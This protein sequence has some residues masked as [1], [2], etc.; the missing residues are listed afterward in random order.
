MR[1]LLLCALLAVLCIFPSAT[2]AQYGPGP[3]PGCIAGVACK[4]GSVAIGGATIGS[5]ALGVTGTTTISGAVSLGSTLSA[6]SGNI[7]GVSFVAN[8]SGNGVFTLRSGGTTISSPA[9]NILKFGSADAASPVAQTLSFQGV[10]AGTSNIAGVN[11]T[12]AGSQ[13]TGTGAGGSLILQTAP[14]GTTGSAQ[15]AEVTAFSINSAGLLA[16]PTITSD[17]TRTDASVCED[18]TT[19]AFYSGSGTLGI[20]LG[21]SSARYKHDIAPLTVGLLQIMRLRPI[22]YYLNADH[23]DPMHLLYGFTAE[24]MQ[25]VTP[26]LV[27]LDKSGRP[28][29]ADYV[30]LIPV[31]VQA[32]QQ[33]Q[34]EIDAL[35]VR[36]DNDD[37]ILA[38]S[39]TMDVSS[40]NFNGS[41]K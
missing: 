6:L 8:G 10:V 33:Q 7:N 20:C 40:G 26:A 25:T 18:T 3:A 21:T 34:V 23:G 39:M 29:T 22:S 17:A 5:D 38:K 36:I 31:L 4:A 12:I 11:A 41:I 19:H 16:N 1:N 27:G 37:D 2:F 15:N 24:D 13:G 35:R 30:G 28:N 14:A 9:N 32:I